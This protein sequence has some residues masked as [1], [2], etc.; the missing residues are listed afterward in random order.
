M[1]VASAP[2]RELHLPERRVPLE[3]VAGEPADRRTLELVVGEPRV[4][5]DERE[6]VLDREPTALPGCDFG[7]E[8]AAGLDRATEAV[9]RRS[10]RGHER[11]FP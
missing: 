8:D 5:R 11:M 7:E 6:S 3:R 1:S 2:A 10:L 4:Q 9:E